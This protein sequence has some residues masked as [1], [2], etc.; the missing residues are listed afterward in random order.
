MKRPT[1]AFVTYGP[2]ED[3]WT[4][5]YPWTRKGTR[6]RK[7]LEQFLEIAGYTK[8]ADLEG[9]KEALAWLQ[10]ILDATPKDLFP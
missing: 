7:A 4:M 8:E 5:R 9:R 10:S 1:K 2:N 6:V 3:H